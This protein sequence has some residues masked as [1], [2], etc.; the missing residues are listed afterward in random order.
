MMPKDSEYV[1]LVVPRQDVK[2]MKTRLEDHNLLDKSQKIRLVSV[3]DETWI[4][5]SGYDAVGGDGKD[6]F[7]IPT[8]LATTTEVAGA[9]LDAEHDEVACEMIA[10]HVRRSIGFE[11]DQVQFAILKNAGSRFAQPG[12]H[13]RKISGPE[14]LAVEI[15]E[16]WLKRIS[17][18]KGL[19]NISPDDLVRD[20]HRHPPTQTSEYNVYPPL[21][22]LQPPFFRAKTPTGT[23]DAAKSDHL[24]TLFAALCKAFK[25][26]H[27][28]SNGPIPVHFRKSDTT[29]DFMLSEDSDA[30]VNILRSPTNFTPLYGDFGPTLSYEETPSTSDFDKA[31]WCSTVQNSVNQTW[32][33]RYTMFSKGNLSEKA[34]IQ[35][36]SSLSKTAL[37]CAIDQTSAIDLYAGIGYFVFSYAKKGVGKIFCWEINGWSIEGMRKGAEANGWDMAVFAGPQDD[38]TALRQAAGN[39]EK[40]LAFPSSNQDAA[41]QVRAIRDLIPPV[42]HVNCGYLPS[43]AASWRVAV[44]ALDP[45]LGGWIH[46][47][48]NIP[49]KELDSHTA[50]IVDTFS[51]LVSEVHSHTPQRHFSVASEHFERVKSYSPGIIHCV[52]DI[53]IKP[54]P[55]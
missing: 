25:V 52:I 36:L 15:L 41:N 20:E 1:V 14:N 40:I 43:S 35:N 46:A 11:H 49:K 4:P 21:L 2:T 17:G 51:T 18:S 50:K 45:V 53:A 29:K 3:G 47:H 24:P 37:G 44:E 48:E 33:P 34:R 13:G 42:R 16:E 22:L 32:A 39:S 23:M 31:F 55:L 9:F 30:G 27:I 19:A 26:T 12:E 5:G 10:S 54:V 38:H 7:C 8:L 6:A 28:A